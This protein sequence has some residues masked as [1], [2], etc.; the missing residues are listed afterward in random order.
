MPAT[1]CEVFPGRAQFPAPNGVRCVC[2]RQGFDDLSVK[3]IVRGNG[4]RDVESTTMVDDL[5]H[6]SVNQR[7]RPG[8]VFATVRVAL[9]T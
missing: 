9:A 7:L 6:L 1:S 3:V 4:A 2:S 5:Q 8:L